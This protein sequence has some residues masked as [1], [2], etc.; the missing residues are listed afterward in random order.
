MCQER[1]QGHEKTESLTLTQL[2]QSLP[3][4]S[5]VGE[6][7]LQQATILNPEQL[8]VFLQIQ[9]D[10]SATMFTQYVKD[11]YY[12]TPNDLKPL[13]PQLKRNPY[14]PSAPQRLHKKQVR[15]E[16]VSACVSKPSVL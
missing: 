6:E 13:V 9:R 15:Q 2:K 10:K 12:L 3:A 4:D 7:V 16:A 1:W 14:R 11:N 5:V 8:A